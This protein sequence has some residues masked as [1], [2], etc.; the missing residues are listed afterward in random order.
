MGEFIYAF[1]TP[2]VDLCGGAGSSTSMDDGQ[3]IC[4]DVS[5]AVFDFEN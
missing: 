3:F 1:R 2:L 4:R 5:K